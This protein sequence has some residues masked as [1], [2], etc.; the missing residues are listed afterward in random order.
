VGNER[1]NAACQRALFYGDYSYKTIVAILVK[2]LGRV[3][4]EPDTD[5]SPMPFHGNIRVNKYYA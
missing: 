1:L 4:L 2:H 5:P 3:P